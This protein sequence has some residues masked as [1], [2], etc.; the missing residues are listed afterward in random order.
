MSR[1]VRNSLSLVLTGA[2][3]NILDYF[4]YGHVVD[5][6]RFSFRGYSFPVFNC[7][8]VWI[9]LG[10]SSLFFEKVVQKRIFRSKSA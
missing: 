4:L 1:F 6:F 7:A 8:D 9:F 3:G 5:L 2:L 10:V